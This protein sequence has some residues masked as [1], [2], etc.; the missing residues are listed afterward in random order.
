MKGLEETKLSSLREESLKPSG[1]LFL[2][3]KKLMQTN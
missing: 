2:K 1:F 3:E